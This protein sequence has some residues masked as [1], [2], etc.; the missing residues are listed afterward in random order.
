MVSLKRKMASL[1]AYAA[2]TRY[3]EDLS[4]VRSVSVREFSN[5]AVALSRLR[6]PLTRMAGIVREGP[7]KTSPPWPKSGHADP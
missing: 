2:L 7:S 1:Q 4:L 3:L 5:D 6:A